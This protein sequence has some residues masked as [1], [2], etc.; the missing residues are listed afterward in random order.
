MARLPLAPRPRPWLPVAVLVLSVVLTACGGSSVEK[1]VP[2][3]S[4][5]AAATPAPPVTPEAIESGPGRVRA[6][7]EAT[8]RAGP[9]PSQAEITVRYSAQAE[10]SARLSR[11]RLLFDE[12]LAEDS[13]ALSQKEYV[14]IATISA[15]PGSSHSY[16][17]IAE[18]PGQPPNSVRSFIACPGTPATRPPQ[19]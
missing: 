18:A 7:I 16:Q 5:S 9:G 4:P 11:V 15:Q 19:V 10:G 3:P 12:K 6:T 2:A 1:A 8:C 14:R 13:G 17:V